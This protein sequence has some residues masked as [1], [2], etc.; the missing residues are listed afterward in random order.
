MIL[1]S[2]QLN[3]STQ[4]TPQ[5][6]LYFAR[7][8]LPKASPLAADDAPGLR[9]TLEAV[10]YVCYSNCLSRHVYPLA[11]DSWE[12]STADT[13]S[14]LLLARRDQLLGELPPEW[15]QGKPLP[16]SKGQHSLLV[17][18]CDFALVATLPPAMVS[19]SPVMLHDSAAPPLDLTKQLG[20]FWRCEAFAVP[21]FLD[22]AFILYDD[23]DWN[24]RAALRGD[25]S[26]RAEIKREFL[27]TKFA[28]R[29]TFPAKKF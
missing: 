9:L 24:T 18:R 11:R 19:E 8:T 22:V 21:D 28:K 5:I 16:D 27:G 15:W 4:E 7:H 29:M 1:E 13:V 10:F 20:F 14:E 12:D 17:D 26:E 2:D 6:V 3:P 23:V 25:T